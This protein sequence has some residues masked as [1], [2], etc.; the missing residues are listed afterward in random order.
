M[1]GYRQIIVAHLLQLAARRRLGGVGKRGAAR[2]GVVSSSVLGRSVP[3]KATRPAA[4]SLRTKAVVWIRRHA[5]GQKE[6]ATILY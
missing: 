6:G 4:S 5:C 3:E 2:A 1:C